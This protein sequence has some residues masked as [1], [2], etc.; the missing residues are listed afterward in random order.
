[1][2]HASLPYG[3]TATASFEAWLPVFL[4]RRVPQRSSQSSEGLPKKKTG[5]CQN[6]DSF[7]RNGERKRL[8]DRKL[9]DWAKNWT[10]SNINKYQISKNKLWP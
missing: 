8:R 6:R 3:L 2:R 7:L 9:D 1:M 10:N 5:D 4:H